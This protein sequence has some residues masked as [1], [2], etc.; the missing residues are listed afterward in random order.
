[1]GSQLFSPEFFGIGRSWDRVI[2]VYLSF[3]WCWEE[4]G[5]SHSCLPEFFIGVGR[6]WDGV[7]VVYLSFYWCWEELG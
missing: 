5:W 4:L 3:Y 2:V 6:S 1:M 7:I